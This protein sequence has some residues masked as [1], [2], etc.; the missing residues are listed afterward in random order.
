MLNSKRRLLQRAIVLSTIY[1]SPRVM[2]VN[3]RQVKEGQREVEREVDEL[4]SV[5]ALLQYFVLS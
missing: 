1:S 2:L 3:L 4:A 5:L